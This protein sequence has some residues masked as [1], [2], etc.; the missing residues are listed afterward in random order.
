M[1]QRGFPMKVK[2]FVAAANNWMNQVPGRENAEVMMKIDGDT[3]IAF[4]SAR[5]AQHA[6]AHYF[7]MVQDD[8][9]TQFKMKEVKLN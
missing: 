3:C 7:I 8:L 9:G 1:P 5:E 2:D 4:G 6:G